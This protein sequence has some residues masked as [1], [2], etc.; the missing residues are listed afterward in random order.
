VLRNSRGGSYAEPYPILFDAIDPND[1]Y[2]VTA[3][4]PRNRDDRQRNRHVESGSPCGARRPPNLEL[5]HYLEWLI[6]GS[7]R[8][9]KRIAVFVFNSELDGM[10]RVCLFPINLQKASNCKWLRIG[11]DLIPSAP[12]DEK[13]A[14]SDL[15][16]IRQ[17]NLRPH[18]RRPSLPPE[19]WRHDDH[20]RLSA[21]GR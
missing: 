13:E 17:K 14:L 21:A 2:V 6:A 11:A 20:A 5:M 1:E 8:D 16:A 12:E 15:C 10:L 18:R 3:R 7:T 19:L 4:Y 9:L